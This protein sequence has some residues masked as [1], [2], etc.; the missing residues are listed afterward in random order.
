[1]RLQET[2]C[3]RPWQ[4]RRNEYRPGQALDRQFNTGYCCISVNGQPRRIMSGMP[5]SQGC[6]E[7]H[8]AVAKGSTFREI[9]FMICVIS[10]IPLPERR[11]QAAIARILCCCDNFFPGLADDIAARPGRS[12]AADAAAP[13][14][15]RRFKDLPGSSGGSAESGMSCMRRSAACVG[16]QGAVPACNRPS[17]GEGVALRGELRGHQI[18]SRSCRRSIRGT[19]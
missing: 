17:L 2:S 12:S 14:G 19:C 1:M 16:R 15:Q 6:S 4:H 9:R 3:S 13:D 10:P 7:P 18:K 11:E 8:A 5:Y